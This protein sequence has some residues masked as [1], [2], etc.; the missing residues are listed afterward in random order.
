MTRTFPLGI[1][2]GGSGVKGAPVDLDAGDWAQERLRIDTPRPATPEA[3]FDVVEEIVGN[4]AH[5]IGDTALGVTVP[6]VVRRGVVESAANID[7]SWIGVAAEAELTRRLGRP[8]R[9]INDADAAGVAELRYGAAQGI[10]GTVLV[11]TLGTGIGSALFVDGV[12]L[13]N[14]ELGHLEIDGYDAEKRASAA[15]RKTED[16]NWAQ[17]AARLQRYFSHVEMLFS[18]DLIVIGGGVSRKSA[19]FVPLLDLK[20][21]I[22]PAQLRNRAGII[23]AAL[24]ATQRA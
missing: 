10:S 16:L 21:P 2:I 5:M 11:A 13:P 9:V 6:A 8:V 4:Y 24:H 22:V 18:P 3:V 12:L 23:G 7:P 15:I 19:M 17:W 14:T 1:D 20:A